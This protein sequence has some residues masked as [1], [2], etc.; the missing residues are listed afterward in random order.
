[1]TIIEAINRTDNMRPNV[2][3]QM[4]KIEWLSQLD[5]QVKALYD[6]Y[7]GAE[8]SA[9]QGY[10]PQTPMET[11]LLIQPP[12]DGIYLKWL[13]AQIER[14][15]GEIERYNEAITLY[16]TEFQAFANAYSRSHM[17]KGAGRRFLF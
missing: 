6:G 9:F 8:R 10:G 4:T 2:Y 11:V 12:Y 13:E 16:N 1:M 7:Q 14:S 5:G 15:N 17:A 3:D